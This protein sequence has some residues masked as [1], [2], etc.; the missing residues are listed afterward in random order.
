M[1][2]V[3]Y[4]LEVG[5]RKELV[6]PGQKVAHKGLEGGVKALV[7]DLLWRRLSKVCEQI[8]FIHFDACVRA[9]VGQP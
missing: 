4:L 3:R 5:Y 1:L 8:S 2:T 6:H 7:E 9:C